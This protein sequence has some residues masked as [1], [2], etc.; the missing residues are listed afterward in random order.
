MRPSWSLSNSTRRARTGN[1]TRIICLEGRCAGRYTTRTKA[2]NG[3]RTRKSA[4]AERCVAITRYLHIRASRRIRTDSLLITKQL[5]F[6]CAREAKS[7]LQESNL[8][9]LLIRQVPYH[10]TKLQR[11]GT[12]GFEPATIRLTAD[13]SAAKAMFPQQSALQLTGKL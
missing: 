3:T 6:R 9:K 5:R 4:L 7:E 13:S 10:W 2:S 1:R 8:R 12:A 11:A